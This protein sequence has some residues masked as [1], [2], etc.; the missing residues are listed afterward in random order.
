MMTIEKKLRTKNR[1]LSS[2]RKGKHLSPPPLPFPSPPLPPPGEPRRPAARDAPPLP[3]SP[4]WCAP[5]LPRQSRGSDAPWRVHPRSRGAF[6]A[7]LQ[8]GAVD[9][10]VTHSLGD[11]AHSTSTH[12]AMS[13]QSTSLHGLFGHTGGVRFIRPS[14]FTILYIYTVGPDIPRVT[15][16]SA[17]NRYF[18]EQICDEVFPQ[19]YMY[20]QY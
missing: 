5:P 15:F 3:P 13:W 18:S 19:P 20:K 7:G 9:G 2:D 1:Y 14:K 10:A 16:S 17:Q 4:A 8:S 11:V 6:D 12:L